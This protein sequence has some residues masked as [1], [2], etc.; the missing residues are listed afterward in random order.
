MNT[1]HKKEYLV[2]SKND[3]EEEDEVE[4]PVKPKPEGR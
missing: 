1:F 4:P 2:L 3:D